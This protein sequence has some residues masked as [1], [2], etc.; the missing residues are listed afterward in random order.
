MVFILFDFHHY[1]INFNKII[2][3]LL[4]KIFKNNHH[5]LILKKFKIFFKINVSY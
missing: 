2:F 5:N 3:N 1:Q 4:L